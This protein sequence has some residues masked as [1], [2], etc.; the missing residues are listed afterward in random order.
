MYMYNMESRIRYS[1]TAPNGKLSPFALLDYYQD[2]ATFHS[3]DLGFGVNVLKEHHVFWALNSWQIDIYEMPDFG[4]DIVITTI[5]YDMRGFLGSRNF[6]LKNKEGKVLSVANSLWS[7]VNR[8]NGKPSPTLPGMAEVFGSG[9]KID[10]EYMGRKIT[11]EAGIEYETMPSFQIEKGN[12]DTNNHVNNSQYVK[13]ASHYIDDVDNI[14]RIRA[15]YK[16][17]AYLGDTF[18]PKVYKSD[19][20]VLVVFESTEEKTYASVEFTYGN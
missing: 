18:I 12:L 17:Q 3:E 7:F 11:P 4:E 16:Q 20:M 1:E 10:M 9:E 19:D 8:D 13:L 14:R 6:I 15:E 5:P 2:I